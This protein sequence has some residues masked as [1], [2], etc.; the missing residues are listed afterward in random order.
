MT[1][2]EGC[3]ICGAPAPIRHCL[4]GSSGLRRVL[5]GNRV[6]LMMCLACGALWCFASHGEDVR[7]P[8]GIRWTHD[9][10]DWQRAYDLDDG[11]ALSRWHRRQV[12][13]LSREAAHPCG[14]RACRFTRRLRAR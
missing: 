1:I 9:P 7:Q 10:R 6:D 13:D 2:P 8:V 12:R 5:F 11:V 3:P 14:R 4:D